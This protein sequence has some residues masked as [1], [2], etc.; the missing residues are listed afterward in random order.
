METLGF[1]VSGFL[2]ANCIH[3]SRSAVERLGIAQ[4]HKY[5]FWHGGY[6]MECKVRQFL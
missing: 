2:I 5:K 4:G 6:P 3:A 1:S